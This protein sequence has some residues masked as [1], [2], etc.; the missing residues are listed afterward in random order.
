MK[1]ILLEPPGQRLSYTPNQKSEIGKWK[2]GV[3]Q[4]TGAS[5]KVA[6]GKKNGGRAATSPQRSGAATRNAIVLGGSHA[7]ATAVSCRDL[8]PNA[9][10]ALTKNLQLSEMRPWKVETQVGIE[11]DL[12]SANGENQRFEESRVLYIRLR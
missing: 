5:P 7:V 1:S 9:P 3:N 11:K 12:L 4:G 2:E 10:S 6:N 8:L